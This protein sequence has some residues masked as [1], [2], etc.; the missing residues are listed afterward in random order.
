[1]YR[2]QLH[3]LVFPGTEVLVKPIPGARP[4][5]LHHVLRATPDPALHTIAST[6]SDMIQ[7]VE[8]EDEREA[9][10][11]AVGAVLGAALDGADDPWGPPR[12]SEGARAHAGAIPSPLSL[13]RLAGS[14]GRVLRRHRSIL[15]LA[16]GVSLE[17]S[18][19][20]LEQVASPGPSVAAVGLA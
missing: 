3:I 1:M 16:D 12:P 13:P 5:P 15:G 11:E 19:N 8:D 9:V 10:A 7:R 6:L 20:D 18:A 17:A 4:P 14:G 2:R